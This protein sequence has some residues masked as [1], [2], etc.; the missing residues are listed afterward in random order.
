M[1]EKLSY[2]DLLNTLNGSIK[3]HGL[4]ALWRGLIPTLWRDLPFSIFYWTAYERFKLFIMRKFG[5]RPTLSAFY[6]GATAGALATII[7]HPFDTVKS[8]RQVQLG[9][10]QPQ[11]S[12]RTAQ[13]LQKML[14]EQGLRSWYKGL[15]PRLLKVSPACAIMI[16][17]IEFFRE[18]VFK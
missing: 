9:S 16:S 14:R 8:I 6:S 1:S 15:V 7:T 18:Y 4:Q 13:I 17:T 12:E 3:S 10:K 5:T 2:K 11:S